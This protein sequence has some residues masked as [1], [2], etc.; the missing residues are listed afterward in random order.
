MD[1]RCENKK[2]AV[3]IEPGPAVIEVSCRSGF[4]GAGK[5]VTVLHRF[6]TSSG[7]LLSTKRFK[8]PERGELSASQ[9]NPAALRAS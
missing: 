3:V 5:G 6:D 1:L 7:E 9:H 8:T 2:H 4:C